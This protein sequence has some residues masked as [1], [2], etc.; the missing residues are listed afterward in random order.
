MNLLFL[1]IKEAWLNILRGRLRSFLTVLGVVI[2]IASVFT[3]LTLSSG[4]TSTVN[5]ELGRL[6]SGVLQISISP[7]AG[8]IS[9]NELDMLA[10]KNASTYVKSVV[11]IQNSTGFYSVSGRT[12][13]AMVFGTNEQY[14]QSFGMSLSAGQFF[15]DANVRNGDPVGLVDANSIEQGLL[16]P[17]ILGKRIQVNVNGN[18]LSVKIIGTIKSGFSV[19]GNGGM[20]AIPESAKNNI[21]ITVY[22]PYT[23]LKSSGMV[24]N[25]TSLAV[26]LSAQDQ[27]ETYGRLAVN[28]LNNMH[29]VKDGFQASSLVSALDAVNNILNVIS[30]VLAVIAGISL[31]VGGIGVMNIMLVSV[32][33][34]TREI[35]IRKALGARRKDI[36][37]QFLIE[38]LILTLGGG[39]IGILIGWG[40]SSAASSV[41]AIPMLITW[42]N[43]LLSVSFALLIGVFFGIYPAYRAGLL[44]PV[45]ALRYE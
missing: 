1:Q 40:L 8:N 6:G 7:S 15:S 35:G 44:N 32:T 16:P 42:Q 11:P 28:I 13:M 3:I 20:S 18:I 23:T 27:V 4:V 12:G 31:V 19:G 38:A 9:F 25:I 14:F 36:L 5:Q 45:E 24:S 39:V 43:L 34:R 41:I 30:L 22:V 29:H 21:P 26:V 2:G 37:F 33:E 17:N 10:L